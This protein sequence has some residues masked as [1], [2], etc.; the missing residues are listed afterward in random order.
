MKSH[1]IIALVSVTAIL[2]GCVH[3][4]RHTDKPV[5]VQEI[6]IVHPGDTLWDLSADYCDESQDRREWIYEVEELN[7]TA[8]IRSGQEI[9][10]L[11]KDE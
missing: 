8:N 2:L 1:K 11:V 5:Y 7:G 9:I 4:F 6:Y 3:Q 10:I